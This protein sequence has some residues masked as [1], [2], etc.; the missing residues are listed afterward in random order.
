MHIKALINLLSTPPLFYCGCILIFSGIM[1]VP[2]LRRVFVSRITGWV[3]ALGIPLFFGLALFDP[4]FRENMA[5]T[6][7]LPVA[8]FLWAAPLSFWM[9]LHLAWQNDQRI[10]QGQEV[11]EAQETATLPAWPHLLFRE[12]LATLIVLIALFAWSMLVQA[13]LDAPAD[14]AFS[15][16]PSKSAWYLLGLQELLGYFDP[17]FAG[18]VLPFMAVTGLMLIPFLD[19]DHKGSGSYAFDHRRGAVTLFLFAWLFLWVLPIAIGAFLRGPNWNFF[20]P[21]EPWDAGKAPNLA[22]V[23]LPPLFGLLALAA[24]FIGLPLLL[25]LTS[26]KGL[27]Q[28]IGRIRY[29]VFMFYMTVMFLVPIKMLLRWLFNLKYFITLPGINLN[30]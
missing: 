4:N 2:G 9:F 10:K 20:G 26:A 21:F 25:G 24:Y 8:L 17:W 3:L 11:R 27:R 30:L 12:F 23:R 28:S 13:P 18:I 16:N 5:R 1:L 15:P 19:P 22:G 29:W 6:D 7:F 14:P